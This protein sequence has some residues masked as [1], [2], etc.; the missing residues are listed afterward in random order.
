MKI[1]VYMGTESSQTLWSLLAVLGK[2]E[3]MKTRAIIEYIRDTYT[4]RAIRPFAQKVADLSEE[5]INQ[6]N[7]SVS[8]GKVAL[9]Y[10]L[11]LKKNRMLITNYSVHGDSDI[12]SQKELAS[13]IK[14]S[15]THQLHNYE[16]YR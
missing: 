8:V 15:Y 11:D 5:Q 3:Q 4:G 7:I 14:N 1:Y 6:L 12:A 10:F 16:P 2:E 13:Q 9:Y